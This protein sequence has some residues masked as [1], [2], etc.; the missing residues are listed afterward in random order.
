M[1]S[2][3]FSNIEQDIRKNKKIIFQSRGYVS[4]SKPSE[5]FKGWA[6]NNPIPM[7]LLYFALAEVDNAYKDMLH[8]QLKDR[9]NE[10]AWIK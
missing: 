3:H 7:K 6:H 1:T 5:I 10:D 9:E 4:K 2:K 8:K